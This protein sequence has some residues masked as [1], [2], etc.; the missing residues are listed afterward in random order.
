MPRT[1]LFLAVACVLTLWASTALAQ[2]GGTG[3]MG[4]MSGGMTG[5]MG[6]MGMGG[7]GSG[8]SGLP[9]GLT[10]RPIARPMNMNTGN[11]N[12]GG[13]SRISPQMFRPGGGGGG[14]GGGFG[15]R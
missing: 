5:G 9:K 8:V 11:M 7:M 12:M 13:P 14:F 6:G 1:N 10:N 3:G 4:G 15:R 2:R